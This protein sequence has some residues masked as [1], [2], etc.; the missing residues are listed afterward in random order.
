MTKVL[1][2][3]DVVSGVYYDCFNHADD[4]D[5]CTIMS[6]LSGVLALECFEAGYEPTVYNEG[7]VRI[8]MPS[9]DEKTVHVFQVVYKAI[10]QAARQYPD[11]IKIY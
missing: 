5:A 3:A 4:H 2:N 9:V 6:T 8:D 1:M 10:Q 7:H 11:N